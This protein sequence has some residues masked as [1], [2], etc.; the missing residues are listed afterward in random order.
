MLMEIWDL[1]YGTVN[2]SM[3]SLS[4]MSLFSATKIDHLVFKKRCNMW[5]VFLLGANNA[6]GRMFMA[7]AVFSTHRRRLPSSSIIAVLEH[8]PS[9][10]LEKLK[11]RLMTQSWDFTVQHSRWNVCKPLS[12]HSFLWRPL[13]E[14]KLVLLNSPGKTRITED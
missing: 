3:F 6:K 13:Q 8:K 5:R 2:K 1:L 14:K 10:A 7:V 9:D 4:A 11:E 12:Y